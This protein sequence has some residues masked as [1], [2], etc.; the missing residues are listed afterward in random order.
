MGLPEEVIIHPLVLL[1]AVDHYNRTCKDTKKRA[2][3]VLLG[4]NFKGKCDITNSF[5][6][7]FEEDQRNPKIWYLDHNY[8][9]QMERMFRKIN[10]GYLVASLPSVR[11]PHTFSVSQG[12][13][14]RVLQYWS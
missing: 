1:S 13:H 3:G 5:A 6:V 7:P 12:A 2:V 8:L 9:D 4:S 14:R 11:D 10:G